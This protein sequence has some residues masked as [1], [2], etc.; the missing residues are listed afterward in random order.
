MGKRTTTSS[1]TNNNE[2]I[3][4]MKE[5][6]E[7]KIAAPEGATSQVSED[8]S[9]TTII[10]F[11]ERPVKY[12]VEEIHAFLK[13]VFHVE[14]DID[15]LVYIQISPKAPKGWGSRPSQ[16][17]NARLAK[18]ETPMQGYYSTATLDYTGD[19]LR[20]TKDA[21]RGYHVL[22]LDDIGTKIPEA[23]IPDCMPP[24]YIIESSAGNFQF[25][26]VLDK[27]ITD[28]AEAQAFMHL[29]LDAGLTDGGGCMPVKKVRLP[30]GVNGKGQASEERHHFPV[31]LTEFNP[32]E[33]WTPQELLDA[34][35]IATNWEKHREE[36]KTRE[37]RSRRY[38]VA[39]WDKDM[40]WINPKTGMHDPIVEW[41]HENKM[42]VQ[43]ST[44][45]AFMDI[46]C[47]WRAEHSESSLDAQLAGYVPLGAGRDPNKRGFNC[48][49]DACKERKAQEFL[50]EVNILGGPEAPVS[51][52]APAEARNCVYNPAKNTVHDLTEP[53][54][55]SA[56]PLPNRN[57]TTR[58]LFMP[59]GKQVSPHTLW[60]SQKACVE[61]AGE[62]WQPDNPIRLV[63][64]EEGKH[65]LN[66]FSIP[67]YPEVKPDYEKYGPFE[68]HI[69]MLLPDEEECEYLLDW[70]AAKV[71]H[72]NYR[73]TAMVITSKV[74]GVGKS[75][76]FETLV[77]L[78]G[79]RNTMTITSDKLLSGRF[80]D[81]AC[82]LLVSVD[83]ALAHE[84]E[85]KAREAYNAFKE[86]VD[87]APRTISVER[88]YMVPLQ[89]QVAASFMLFSNHHD[90]I[91]IPEDDRRFYVAQA[92]DERQSPTY[93]GDYG[94]WL[95]KTGWEA[96]VWHW[97]KARP[98]DMDKLMS[99]PTLNESKQEMVDATIS[100]LQLITQASVETWPTAMVPVKRCLEAVNQFEGR[101]I[102]ERMSSRLRQTHIK[103]HLTT[104][105]KAKNRL[106]NSVRGMWKVKS[107]ASKTDEVA[108]DREKA[109]TKVALEEFT[110]HDHKAAMD[111]WLDERGYE[112]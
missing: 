42:V 84:D 48:F 97:L 72:P 11:T 35:G 34:A 92:T 47:P 37:H 96:H 55:I 40:F 20:H 83:E 64:D 107:T 93:F 74:Q 85:R 98:V 60:V 88:K 52:Y 105:P 45:S 67:H 5:A 61:I 91:Y 100:P 16:R 46:L 28:Y 54:T 53:G 58:K 89:S 87:P 71:Q 95:A 4:K 13:A 106:T 78:F 10:P 21:F 29:F 76:L 12:D 44:G 24:T 19:T 108:F 82:K 110:M 59:S 75:L 79:P 49:H 112:D 14:Q 65:H 25:G 1:Q 23:M 41:L 22:V 39:A 63:K 109:L 86:I 27:P 9:D 81:W 3:R 31:R 8:Y 32:A 2:E 26:Y 77:K 36:C 94:R 33:I 30:C 90:A 57:M 62:V 43:E 51:E 7:D 69:R 68:T 80:N 17:L 70:L 38:E 104:V 73:G 103:M 15:D 66:Q 6:K 56:I 102:T 99:P 101:G 50:T 18:S 111:A